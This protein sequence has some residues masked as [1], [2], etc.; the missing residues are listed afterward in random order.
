LRN[1][2]L[3]RNKIKI[4]NNYYPSLFEIKRKKIL[5]KWAMKLSAAAGSRV[6]SLSAC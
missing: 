5:K 6:V 3:K 2:E 1:K 4:V